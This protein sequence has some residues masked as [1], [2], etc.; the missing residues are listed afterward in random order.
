[1]YAF[2]RL[3]YIKAPEFPNRSATKSVCYS[4]E[5]LTFVD[6]INRGRTRIIY[7]FLQSFPHNRCAISA[8]PRRV[9]SRFTRLSILLFRCIARGRKSV[10]L[11]NRIRPRKNADFSLRKPTL[12][13]LLCAEVYSC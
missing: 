10:V 11:L 3:C 1:M 2:R 9:L 6:L 12:V 5:V 8:R 4:R 13:E 7:A